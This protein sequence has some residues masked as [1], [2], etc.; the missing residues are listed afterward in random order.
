MGDDVEKADEIIETK[1]LQ[2][3]PKQGMSQGS[4]DDIGVCVTILAITLL[5]IIVTSIKIIIIDMHSESRDVPRTRHAFFHQ[6]EDQNDP[7]QASNR[8]IRESK[9]M[10]QISQMLAIHSTI[11]SKALPGH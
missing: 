7:N 3:D 6:L 11:K 4:K 10:P 5:A 1:D 2:K 9:L 8:D